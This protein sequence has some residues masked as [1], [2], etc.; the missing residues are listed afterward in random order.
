LRNKQEQNVSKSES[1][2]S[3]GQAAGLLR[4]DE[5]DV[6]NGGVTDGGCIRLPSIISY[7]QPEPDGYRDVFA[8]YV[9]GRH[10]PV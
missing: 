5:L 2:T 1:A 7:P 4:D 6:A 3:V 9:I 8:R 10:L